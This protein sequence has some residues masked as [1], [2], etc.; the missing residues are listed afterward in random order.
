MC[1]DRKCTGEGVIDSALEG[2]KD[3]KEGTSGEEH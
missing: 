2:G 1:C 3:P